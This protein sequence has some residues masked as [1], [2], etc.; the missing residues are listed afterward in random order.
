MPSH[1]DPPGLTRRRLLS[2]FAVIGTASG[3][4]GAGTWAIF[5]DEEQAV[6]SVVAGTVDI[7]LAPKGQ[8]GDEQQTFVVEVSEDDKR[9]SL[10]TP[11]W[12]QGTLPVE[13]GLAIED[14]S[15]SSDDEDDD[16]E[17]EDGDDDDDDNELGDALTLTF[18]VAADGELDADSATD[19]LGP[20]TLSEF[21]P[22]STRFA[23]DATLAPDAATRLFVDWELTDDDVEAGRAEVRLT[24]HARH[25]ED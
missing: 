2:S 19:I 23:S 4:A 7:E 9:G 16:D 8:E 3:A 20:K 18:G 5:S 24:V 17:V 11:L 1:S 15:V 22:G 14:V 6:S 10:S 25:T 13:L 12:N 21:Q